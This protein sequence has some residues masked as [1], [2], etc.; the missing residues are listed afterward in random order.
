MV[1]FFFKEGTDGLPFTEAVVAGVGHHDETLE[2]V[3]L[4]FNRLECQGNFAV[5]LRLVNKLLALHGLLEHLVRE[6]FADEP[7]SAVVVLI[8]TF[9]CSNLRRHF[10]QTVN[11]SQVLA[12]NVSVEVIEAAQ[13]FWFH[14][15]LCRQLFNGQTGSIKFATHVVHSDEF[16]E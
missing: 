2:D 5:D 14:W 4:V 6:F 7:A 10:L 8:G 11:D 1:V 3:Q 9:A 15:T 13:F 12:L 16:I